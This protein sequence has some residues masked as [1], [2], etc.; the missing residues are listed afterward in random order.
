M[1]TSRRCSAART[2]TWILKTSNSPRRREKLN[3]ETFKNKLMENSPLFD[4][5][6]KKKTT[7][8]NVRWKSIANY[9][10]CW[11]EC[12]IFWF[13]NEFCIVPIFWPICTLC[14]IL[15]SKMSAFEL[16]SVIFSRE[17]CELQSQWEI[18]T[19]FATKMF[20]SRRGFLFEPWRHS[21]PFGL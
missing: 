6:R 3:S 18:F 11:N 15:N 12:L 13:T 19:D 7:Q 10:I 9:W 2:P 5:L 4:C 14:K 8:F 16:I 20:Q 17:M 1:G 21:A